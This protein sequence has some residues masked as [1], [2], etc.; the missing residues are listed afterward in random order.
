MWGFT[1]NTEDW[2]NIWIVTTAFMS[3]PSSK[4]FKVNLSI[5]ITV[6]FVEQ[7]SQLV[8]V[9]D[10][11]NSFKCLLELLRS[12]GTEAF[13]VKVLEK[14]FSSLSFV[15]CAVG[16][17]TDLFKNDRLDLSKSWSGNN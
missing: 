7:G 4:L 5:A 16:S 14:S 1:S 11:S 6:K 2:I 15:I 17:L 10:T 3:N 12:N 13:Q 8:I 9:E